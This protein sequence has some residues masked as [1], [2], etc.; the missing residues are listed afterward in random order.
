MDRDCLSGLWD[1]ARASS[2]DARSFSGGVPAQ[3]T[4]HVAHSDCCLFLLSCGAETDWQRLVATNIRGSTVD[5]G[6]HH[7]T[8]RVHGGSKHPGEAVQF[9]LSKEATGEDGAAVAVSFCLD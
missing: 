4:F 7:D 1:S 5:E 2:L 6:I 8:Y 3:H 9:F